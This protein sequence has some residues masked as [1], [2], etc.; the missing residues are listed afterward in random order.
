MPAGQGGHARLVSTLAEVAVWWV[1]TVGVWMASL[2]AWSPHEL[3]VAVP[4]AL[5]CALAAAGARRAVRGRWHVP[6]EMLTWLALLPVAIVTDA[7]KVL[8]LPL[9]GGR[10]AG[11]SFR[12][13]TVS[14][15]GDSAEQ[16]GRRA[17]ATIALSSTPGSYVV[18]TDPDHG[19]ALLHVVGP[20][21]ALERAV[22]Q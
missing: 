1:V 10:G 3:E 16:S 13:V 12:T 6:G 2:S 4:C 19:T 20:P 7:V 9:R 8:S 15:R 11:T 18:A 5:L 21:G 14:G 17:V 22:V